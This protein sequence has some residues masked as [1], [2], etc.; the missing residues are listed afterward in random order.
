MYGVLYAI[1][2]EIFPAKDR[3]TGNGLTAMATRLF[4]ILVNSTFLSFTACYT[5]CHTSGTYHC[6]VRQPGNGCAGVHIWGIDYLRWVPHAIVAIRT[7]GQ[8]LDLTQ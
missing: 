3:G 7:S 8:G 5:K 4:G 2:P 1:S 6:L